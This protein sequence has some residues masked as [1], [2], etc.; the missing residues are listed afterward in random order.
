MTVALLNLNT[1]A[2][3]TVSIRP[4]GRADY[5]IIDTVH[6]ET[7]DESVYRR[8][9]GDPA[10]PATLRV[11]VYPVAPKNGNPKM[12]NT[13]AKLTSFVRKTEGDVVTDIAVSG[14]I[15]LTMP[16]GVD[17][18]ELQNF[19]ENL[20][21]VALSTALGIHNSD[22]LTEFQFGVTNGVLGHAETG[23]A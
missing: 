6:D 12:T 5:V 4:L 17:P 9:V 16:D 13:S 21:T 20:I 10:A 18:D 2:I 14:V 8:V 19:V 22:A 11:G 7:K 15:A 1:D 23:S 3:N